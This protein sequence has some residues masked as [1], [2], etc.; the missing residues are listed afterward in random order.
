MGNAQGN[1]EGNAGGNAYRGKSMFSPVWGGSFKP[2]LS[3]NITESNTRPGPLRWTGLR[4]ASPSAPRTACRA[5][6]E[7][8]ASE[9][10]GARRLG[11]G[12]GEVKKC[13]AALFKRVSASQA[14]PIA[15]SP[16][17]SSQLCTG[18]SKAN[19]HSSTPITN[20]LDKT[21]TQLGP[22]PASSLPSWVYPVD[23]LRPLLEPKMGNTF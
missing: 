16:G 3:G 11:G 13:R 2:P 12:G 4:I 7:P 6:C 5:L 18:V 17:L 19:C 10:T 14:R 22:S 21:R 9:Y 15:R 23:V 8:C 1:T 20:A